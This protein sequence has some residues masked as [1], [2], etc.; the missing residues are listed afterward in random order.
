MHLRKWLLCILAIVIVIWA[1][2]IVS[3]NAAGPIKIIKPENRLTADQAKNLVVP[4]LIPASANGYLPHNV[5]EPVRSVDGVPV[6]QLGKIPPFVK[7]VEV[8]LP[9]P[10]QIADDRIS[11]RVVATIRYSGDDQRIEILT[12]KPSTTALQHDT[13]LGNQTIRLQNGSEVYVMTG[14]Q[15]DNMPNRIAMVR[16]DLIIAIT[17]TS[18]VEHLQTFA[19]ELVFH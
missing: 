3:V 13:A 15:R 2:S 14:L 12:M 18:S 5:E 8:N 19:N 1:V 11:Y 17:G 4:P 7:S 6:A 16:D 10:G 9:T